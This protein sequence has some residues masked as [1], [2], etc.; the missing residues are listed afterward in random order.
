MSVGTDAFSQ[1]NF[2]VRNPALEEGLTPKQKREIAEFRYQYVDPI[3]GDE[4]NQELTQS[5]LQKGI[6]L[7]LSNEPTQ[8][9]GLWFNLHAPESDVPVLPGFSADNLL[10]RQ[11]GLLK[12]GVVLRFQ[13][14]GELLRKSVKEHMLNGQGVYFQMSTEG[15]VFCKYDQI[16][17]SRLLFRFKPEQVQE[18]DAKLSSLVREKFPSAFLEESVSAPR[19]RG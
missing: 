3:V 16:L 8:H 18:L 17:G 19:Q 15:R 5:V 12:S 2:F 6:S 1:V 10:V 4:I 13:L 9:R 14:D 11:S 7:A